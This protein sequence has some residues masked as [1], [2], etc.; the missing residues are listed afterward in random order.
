[1]TSKHGKNV[2]EPLAQAVS[3]PLFCPYHIVTSSD[4]ASI[5]EQTMEKWNLFVN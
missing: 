5:T 4:C 3:G 1:M 2:S